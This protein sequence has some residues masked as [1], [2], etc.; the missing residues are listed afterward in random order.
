MYTLRVYFT[1]WE[2]LRHDGYMLLP[3]NKQLETI[4]P[5]LSVEFHTRKYIGEDPDYRGKVQIINRFIGR[6]NF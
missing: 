5:L 6:M 1:E 2:V 3:Y 4:T